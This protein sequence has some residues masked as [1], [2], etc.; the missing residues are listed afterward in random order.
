[1]VVVEEEKLGKEQGNGG[2]SD[3]HN[4]GLR[5]GG[6]DGGRTHVAVTV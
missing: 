3:G 6:D 5:G 2:H 1:M 4:G